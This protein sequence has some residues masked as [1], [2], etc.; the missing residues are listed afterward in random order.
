MTTVTSSS[1]MSH[2]VCPRADEIY[3]RYQDIT[4]MIRQILCMAPLK[5]REQ[6]GCEK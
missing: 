2:R 3:C 1:A 6:R 5:E 4:P